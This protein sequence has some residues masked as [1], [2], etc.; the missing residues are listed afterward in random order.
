M[1]HFKLRQLACAIHDGQL[2]QAYTLSQLPEVREHRRGQKL[3]A[4]LAEL[5]VRRGN[6]HLAAGRVSHAL[7]DC[8]K[9]DS[10]GGN[11]AEVAELRR[12]ICSAMEQRQFAHQQRDQKLAAAQQNIDNGWLTVGVDILGEADNAQAAMLSQQADVQRKKLDAVA[13]KVEQAIARGDLVIAAR[14][15]AQGGAVQGQNIRL[16]ELARR[17]HVGAAE[18]IAANLNRGR[19]DVAQTMMQEL[20]ASAAGVAELRPLRQAI[21]Y[22]RQ[23]AAHIR[24]GAYRQAVETLA[25]AKMLLPDAGWLAETIERAETCARTRECLCSGPLGLLE[26]TDSTTQPTSTP[27]AIAS[28]PTPSEA[29]TAEQSPRP[30]AG[31]LPS[32]FVIQIDGVGGFLTLRDD[33]VKIGPISS[34]N[35]PTLALIATAELPTVTIQ[36]QEGDYVL[37]SEQPIFIGE[38]QIREKLLSDGDKIALSMRCRMKFQ[39]PNAASGTATLLLSSARL[40]R[41]DINHVILMDREVLV[42]PSSGHH[43]VT[44]DGGDTVAFYVRDGRMFC[45]T[46]DPIIIDGRSCSPDTPLAMDTPIQ[47]GRMRIVLTGVKE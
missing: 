18:Q 46:N 41:P 43:I 22:C 26:A 38:R 36:R 1:F 39:R 29:D 7:N 16:V 28:A 15:I 32:K 47:I 3:A 5:L 23:G 25:K 6:E 11:R 2:D 40:P 35:R 4:K 14:L 33:T 44:S 9:A 45:R 24:A 31:A 13:D 8:N 34:S 10:L 37:R 27:G 17:L 21:T 12:A 20:G 30:A 19:L 42:G